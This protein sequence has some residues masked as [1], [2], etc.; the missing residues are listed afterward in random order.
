MIY[1]CIGEHLKHSFSKEIHGA[2]AEYDY[3]I[4][5]I[6]REE[7]GAFLENR[8]F[9]AINVTIPYKEAVLPYLYEIDGKAA[10]IGAVNT[11]VNQNGKLYGYNTDFFGMCALFAHAGI[12]P[13]DK[14]AVI[15]GTGGTSKTA[16]VVLKHLGAREILRVSR[17][18]GPG[19]ITY[20]ALYRDHTDAQIIVNTTPVGMYPNIYDSPVDLSCFPAL[21]GVCD[22]VY[23]PLR[24]ELVSGAR[25][26]GIPAACGL[27]M[28]VAQAVRASE[29][30]IGTQYPAGLIDSIYRRMVAQKENIVLIG[31]PGSGKTTVGKL[32]AEKLGRPF[33]DTDLLI[34]EKKQI[35]IPEIFAKYGETYFRDAEEAVI[36]TL[37][38]QTGAII[39]TGGG[40]VLRQTNVE[41]LK[42]NGRLYYLDRPLE[43]LLPTP[44]RPLASSA[45]AIAS[46]YRERH[47]IYTTVCDKIIDE[48]AT[49]ESA[50]TQIYGE[51]L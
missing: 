39:A 48:T 3:E 27:Y 13:K 10:E 36:R 17:R 11:V 24:T 43:S 16:Q 38:P 37:A 23:N 34:E 25:A 5:E 18:E 32:L 15:L 30:F 31:M 21:K 40:A 46:R 2:I 42:K 12:D 14:K 22:A 9:S 8:P 28:L 7:L 4:R 29:I 26:R 35:P 47:G 33:V 51:M 6:P 44:D 20:E 45:E 50:A 41:L 19:V 1:G 49:P